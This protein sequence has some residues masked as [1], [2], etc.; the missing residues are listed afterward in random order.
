MEHRWGNRREILHAVRVRTNSG[1]IAT[2]T[3]KNI[4]VSGALL[5]TDAPLRVSGHIEVQMFA[6]S[7]V[8]RPFTAVAAHVVRVCPDGF[9]IEWSELSPPAVQLLTE[10]AQP[11]PAT[12]RR[13]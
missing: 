6:R 13:R 12:R 10:E 3:L 5:S 4:S 11:V 7:K 2:G 9:G 8:A 1:V